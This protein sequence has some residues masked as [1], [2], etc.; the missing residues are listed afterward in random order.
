MNIHELSA[1]ENESIRDFVL[2]A[3][4]AGLLRGRVLDYGCGKQPYRDVVEAAGALYEPYDRA[5]W[6][7]GS[8]GNVGDRLSLGDWRD[9]ILCTQVLMYVPDPLDTLRIILMNLV[10]PGGHLIVTYPSAWP[11]IRGHLWNFTKAGMQHLVTEAG[12]EV[13]RH[14]L[15]LALP[16]EGFEV[17]VGYGIVVRRPS[18]G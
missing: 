12:Y 9:A 18:A 8:G 2:E 11:V 6:P 5:T 1:L 3:A 14:E 10:K 17:P 13:V 7:G 15:R 4:V 16:F